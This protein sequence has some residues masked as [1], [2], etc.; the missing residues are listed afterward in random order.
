M[1][2]HLYFDYSYDLQSVVENGINQ[3]IL[4]SNPF[5]INGAQVQ[6]IP[7]NQGTVGLDYTNRGLEVR[8]DGYIVGSN[9]PSERPG[10]NTWNG[11]VQQALK[12]NLAVNVGV[13]NVFN[14]A[15]Q[16]YGY[17]GHAPLIPEN[18][19]F[20]DTTAI[21]QYLDTGSNEEFGL[22]IRSFT[23]TFSTKV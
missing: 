6:G 11:F 7:V 9:N 5:I 14:Q 1:T 23:L 17:F 15:W 22:P 16:R 18:Q 2:R 4:Q 8:M 10:Y 21:Q 12:H 3:N 13:S 20:N 19:Y